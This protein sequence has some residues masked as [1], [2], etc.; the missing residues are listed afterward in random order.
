MAVIHTKTPF[1]TI[2]VIIIIVVLII[3]HFVTKQASLDETTNICASSG[4]AS[5][6]CIESMKKNGV[7]CTER[8]LSITCTKR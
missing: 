5:S 7:S 3:I 6:S 2:L 4:I 1:G 8:S